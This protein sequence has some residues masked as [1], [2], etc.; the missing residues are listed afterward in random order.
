MKFK[1]GFDSGR[2]WAAL[3]IASCLKNV[4]NIRKMKRQKIDV[5]S[6]NKKNDMMIGKK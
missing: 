5:N 3:F 2:L 1:K 4:L 6:K